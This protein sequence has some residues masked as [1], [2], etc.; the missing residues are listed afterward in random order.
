[1]ALR[2]ERVGVAH[3]PQYADEL[4]DRRKVDWVGTPPRISVPGLQL[5]F[6]SLSAKHVSGGIWPHVCTKR[7]PACVL[8]DGKETVVSQRT[9]ETASVAIRRQFRAI[10]GKRSFDGKHLDE[11]FVVVSWSRLFRR[12]RFS[13]AGQISDAR[14][15]WLCTP[16]RLVE[17][18]D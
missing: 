12:I 10:L 13:I 11:Y 3:L 1:M 8:S 5:R 9:S 7:T 18:V 4:C 17:S 16:L 2:K 6:T 15:K 14:L